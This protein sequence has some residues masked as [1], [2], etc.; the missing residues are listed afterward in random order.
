MRSHVTQLLGTLAALTIAGVPGSAAADP[1]G[2]QAKAYAFLDQMMDQHA[3]GAVLRLPQSYTG[4]YLQRVGFTDSVTYDDALVID[5]LLARG[6][7]DDLARAKVLGDS[8]LYVQANDPKKD[9][10]IRAAYAPKPLTG[11]AAVTATDTTSDVGNMAWV[12]QAFAQLYAKTGTRSYLSGAIAIAN[13]IQAKAA[14]TRGA[15]GY[16]GGYDTRNKRITWKSTEH[17]LDVF[18]LFSML[19]AETGDTAWT[20]RAQKA[21]SFTLTMWDPAKRLFWTGTGTDG[22][23]TNKDFVPEDTQTWS[24]LALR[25]PAHAAS[26]DYAIGNL[27]ADDG[28][29]HGTSFSSADR[30]KVWFEGTAHLALA[31]SL[32]NGPGDA[33]KANAYT[34]NIELAQSTAPNHDGNGIVAAS[35]DGLNTGD[36]DKYYASLH[37]GA[38]AW[39][40]LALQKRDPFTLLN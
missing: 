16:T 29:F 22:V 12:G 26:I 36:G 15:G 31:L 33:A 10:R 37:T 9:G 14:D 17:N 20:G 35:H 24:Y 11:P 8:L 23:T 27:S 6:G 21:R 3:S 19:A 38:T 4:G 2:S 13:W 30:S 39:Y 18:A 34:G 25:D 1:A 40:V 5:A 28:T 32:R 7:S